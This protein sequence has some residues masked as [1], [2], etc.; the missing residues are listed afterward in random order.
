M[1]LVPRFHAVAAAAWSRPALMP[2]TCSSRRSAESHDTSAQ[3]AAETFQ[4]F[5]NWVKLINQKCRWSSLR[6]PSL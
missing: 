1:F 4:T 5:R 3:L 6:V 2:S